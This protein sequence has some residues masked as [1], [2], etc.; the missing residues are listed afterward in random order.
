MPYVLFSVAIPRVVA[1]FSFSCI[2][3]MEYQFNNVV[4]LLSFPGVKGTADSGTRQGI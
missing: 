3:L 4:R 1:L 2:A